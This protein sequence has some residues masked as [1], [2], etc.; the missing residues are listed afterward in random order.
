MLFAD[1]MYLATLGSA[2]SVL[3]DIDDARD[4]AGEKPSKSTMK[5]NAMADSY[6]IVGA[7]MSSYSVKLRAKYAEVADKTALDPVLEA[8]GCLAGLRG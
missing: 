4:R 3:D 8:A 7:Q 6:R 1:L 2:T 5:G